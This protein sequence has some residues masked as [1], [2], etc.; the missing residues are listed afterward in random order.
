M[1]DVMSAAEPAGWLGGRLATGLRDVT[2]DLG[3]L[4]SAGR[5]AVCVSF[6]G[7]AT[8][9]RFEH[10]TP[11]PAKRLPGVGRRWRR[12]PVTGARR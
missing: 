1:S 12:G 9:V 8:L 4:D 2:N 3:A 11:W 6:E 10:W 7:Q 5:W